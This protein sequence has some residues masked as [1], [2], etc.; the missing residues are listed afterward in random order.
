MSNS[1]WLQFL[2]SIPKYYAV[3]QTLSSKLAEL[4]SQK[5]N[6]MIGIYFISFPNPL[7]LNTIP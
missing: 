6:L 1:I 2:I 5:R 4:K 3:S 7:N